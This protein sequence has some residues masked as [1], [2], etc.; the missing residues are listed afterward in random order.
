MYSTGNYTHYLVITYNGV[1]SAKTLNHYAVHLTPI[2]YCKSTILQK[3]E[4]ERK[5]RKVEKGRKGG[6]EEGRK[7][8]RKGRKEEGRKEGGREEGRKEERKGRKKEG[9]KEGREGSREGGRKED[10]RQTIHYKQCC[11]IISN[12]KTECTLNAHQKENG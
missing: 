6:R 2:Q 11:S 9:K 7:E 10:V 5:E 8:E 4:K 12:G 1:Q 3:E